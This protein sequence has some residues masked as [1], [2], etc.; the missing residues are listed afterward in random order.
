MSG[1]AVYRLKVG[2]H[3]EVL[4]RADH[5]PRIGEEIV[6]TFD[7]RAGKVRQ[8]NYVVRRVVHLLVAPSDRGDARR[9]ME[10]PV[11]HAKRVRA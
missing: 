8:H 7:D 2:G 3:P 9:A 1:D 6:T 11:V 4:V 5:L 10:P